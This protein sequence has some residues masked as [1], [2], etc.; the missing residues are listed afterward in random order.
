MTN[1]AI[2]ANHS[3]LDTHRPSVDYIFFRI[4]TLIVT[5]CIIHDSLYENVYIFV[6][7]IVALN[8]DICLFVYLKVLNAIFSNISVIS[9]RSALLVEETGGPG[10][11][12]R[13]VAS[14]WQ[15]LSHNVVH[16]GLIE[17]RTHNRCNKNREIHPLH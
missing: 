13:P 17:I 4:L 3:R 8:T 7:L 14:H 5:W 12:H 15:T 1:I 2:R 10:E 9:W 11:N 6:T 16:L